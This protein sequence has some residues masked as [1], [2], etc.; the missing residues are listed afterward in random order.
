MKQTISEPAVT[1]PHLLTLSERKTLSVSGVR[2]VVG[3]N[4]ETAVFC[5]EQGELTVRGQNLHVTRLSVETGDLSLEGEVDSLTYTKT[6]R[7]GSF[8]GRLLR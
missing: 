8:F 7:R 1:M 2:E 3:F 6:V 5:T 4:E